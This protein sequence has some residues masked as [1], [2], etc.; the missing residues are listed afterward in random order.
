MISYCDNCNAPIGLPQSPIK[1]KN[2][3]CVDCVNYFYICATCRIMIYKCE[4]DFNRP[5]NQIHCKLCRREEKI[6]S[7][8]G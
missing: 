1:Y 2:S 8:L 5:F 7:I 3:Q 4:M 6:I